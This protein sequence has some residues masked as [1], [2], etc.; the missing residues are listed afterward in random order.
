M[1]STA[2]FSYSFK[3]E[4]V[5]TSEN[6]AE[7][8]N[9]FEE[10]LPINQLE[11]KVGHIGYA[12]NGSSDAFD[13]YKAILPDDGTLK[14]YVTGKNRGGGAG[15][16][17]MYG[18]DRRRANG[19]FF[20]E[21]IRSSNTAAGATITDTIIINCRAADTIYFRVQSTQ[22]FS[23]Q[24]HYDWQGTTSNDAEP[25][26]AFSTARQ[27]PLDSTY[28]GR[29]GYTTNGAPDANDYYSTALP[30]RGSV[31]VIV[32][33]TNTSGGNGNLRLFGYS[34]RSTSGPVL[35]R[36]ISN[37]STIAAGATIR[38]TINI[39]CM[40]TDTLFLRFTSSGCFRYSFVAT[41]ISMDPIA[42]MTYE[43]LGHTVGFRPQLANA[44]SFIWSFGDGDSSKLKYP[45]KTYKPGVYTARLI[46][47]NSTCNYKDTDSISISVTGVEYYTPK[48]TGVGG[49]ALM[50]I[51]GGGLDSTTKVMLV[52]GTDT[53][54]P[55]GI[56]TN[57]LLNH[58]SAEFN[59]HLVK[60][61]NYDVHIQVPGQ[62]MTTYPNGYLVDTFSYPVTSAEVQGPDRWRLNTNTTFKLVV[63]N[64][65]N[66]TASGVVIGFAWPRDVSVTFKNKF[67]EPQTG[68]ESVIVEGKT[69]SLNRSEIKF[70]YDNLKTVV[71][72]DSFNMKPYK[73][74][75]QY[76]LLP[77]VPAGSTV[78]LPFTAKTTVS[79]SPVFKTFTYIPNQRGSCETPNFNDY[80]G[81]VTAEMIDAVGTIAGDKNIP[82]KTLV[83]TAKIG[84]KHAG[85]ATA[86]ASKKF[87]AWYDGYEYDGDA[88]M[89]DWMEETEANNAFALQTATDELGNLLFDASAAKLVKKYGDQVEFINKRLANNPNMSPE[90]FDKYIDK[91]NSLPSTERL[92]ALTAMYKTTKD[93][94]SLSNK[95]LL[96]Q[97]LAEDCPELKPQV[98][99]LKQELDKEINQRNNK[100]KSTNALTSFDPN[101]INGPVGVGS[102]RY[103][104][105]VDR[106]SFTINFE[107]V[108]TAKASAQVV[109]VR[110]TLDRTKFDLSTFE[111]GG[112]T[113]GENFYRLPGGR[114]QFVIERD[115]VDQPLRVRIN[116]SLDT[117]SG[118]VEWQFTSIDTITKELPVFD[119]F[120]PPNVAKPQGEGSVSFSVKPI[121]FLNDGTVFTNRASIIFDDNAPILTNI[122]QNIL[123]MGRSNST[124]TATLVQDTI[125]N[126]RFNGT[127][128]V[129]GV[130]YYNLFTSI[131]NG[132]WLPF[133]GTSADTMTMTGSIDSTYRFFVVSQDKVGNM[134]LKSA[135]AE[136]TIT[137]TPPLVIV[138]GNISAIAEGAR[139]R[140]DWNTL[141]EDDGDK[142]VVE[143]SLNGRD[144]VTIAMLPARARASAYTVYDEQPTEG[145][146]YYRLKIIDR[147]GSYKYSNVVSVYVLSQKAFVLELYPN[148]VRDVATLNIHGAISGRGTVTIM[149]MMGSVVKTMT[150]NRNQVSIDLSDQPAGTYLVKYMDAKHTEVVKVTRQ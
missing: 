22:A 96:L 129:S 8:N 104:N 47:T 15:Y 9:T 121:S 20:G 31:Q 48:K 49:D 92:E 13:Y 80:H 39:N 127:D 66:V 37:S 10:A 148:P 79:G 117:A 124:M 142:I 2:A 29:I 73:G 19:Q 6:D 109:T 25:N 90:L 35:N 30:G 146:N 97:K 140:I 38:D 137:V 14:V 95:L 55:V 147:N 138:L 63:S 113:I 78:E 62:P 57:S 123:D 4:V 21:Y 125:I 94:A 126:L 3:Y 32:E 16:L 144:F 132:P 116:G 135:T 58:L 68:I 41:H 115:V 86:Y 1:Q 72:I 88:A 87:W 75:M 133:G 44:T 102:N 52:Q 91:L 100:E 50:Q 70:I 136:A 71:A 64:R 54:R 59:L 27:T 53:L 112:I 36:F 82:L 40:P 23:Y 84:Q 81:D 141:S 143:K 60:T 114:K 46:A 149:N 67:I 118:I 77:H 69:Y 76:I 74:F 43:Q 130:G 12:Q 107:N 139:N 98:D 7:P 122:W 56:Y 128:A 17:Y 11:E 5:D 61:G 24:F 110:D 26:N 134:E 99:K 85:S 42:D 18:Y 150:L 34:R 93:A 120:L 33:G 101:E 83:I 65:G 111:Y 105:N 51:F 103:L 45:M 89:Q 28:N 145:R 131:N 108:D 106:H 119:G